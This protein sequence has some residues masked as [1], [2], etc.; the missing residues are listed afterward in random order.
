MP[1]PSSA[2]F[3]DTRTLHSICPPDDDRS[4]GRIISQVD[5]FQDND[6]VAAP[7]ANQQP[8]PPPSESRR[9]PGPS[10]PYSNDQR[11]KQISM[12]EEIQISPSEIL[13]PVSVEDAQ[14]ES[15]QAEHHTSGSGY[16]G[17]SSSM[18]N[19][20]SNIRVRSRPPRV[21]ICFKELS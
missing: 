6:A 14:E 3:V 8:T 17:G 18:S 13:S 11:F 1:T 10:E 16:S 21:L 7:V 4:S 12:S 9:S 2:E 15:E 20:F 5:G 19:E